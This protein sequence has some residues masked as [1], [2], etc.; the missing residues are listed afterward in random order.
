MTDHHD[1]CGGPDGLLHAFLSETDAGGG[2]LEAAAAVESALRRTSGVPLL[3]SGLHGGAPAALLAAWYHR[4]ESPAL[5]VAA[6]RDA[7]LRCADDL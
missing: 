3:L 5:V 4:H 6:D 7:A 1:A 2:L